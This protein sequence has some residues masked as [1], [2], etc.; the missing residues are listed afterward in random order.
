MGQVLETLGGD[1]FEMPRCSLEEG[2]MPELPEQRSLAKCNTREVKI[3]ELIFNEFDLNG[4]GEIDDIE[5]KTGLIKFG[6][7]ITDKTVKKMVRQLDVGGAPSVRSQGSK[8]RGGDDII[9]RLKEKQRNS[10]R[11]DEQISFEEFSRGLLARNSLLY[12]FLYQSRNDTEK[13]VE[14]ELAAKEKA[15]SEEKREAEGNKGNNKGK[16]RKSW[17][18]GKKK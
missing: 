11:K 18:G 17:W 2:L 14:E 16:G 10:T 12:M 8:A 3:L 6:S 5:L 7:I 13:E 15:E 4:N 1:C 9:K